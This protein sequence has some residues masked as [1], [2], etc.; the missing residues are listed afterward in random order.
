MKKLFC[1]LLIFSLVFTISACGKVDLPPLPEVT[2]K[3][4]AAAPASEPGQT[5]QAPEAASS[6]AGD[7]ETIPAAS[8]DTASLPTSRAS[9]RPSSDRKGRPRSYVSVKNQT[10]PATRARKA[11][12]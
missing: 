1:I 2:E 9:R 7:S 5:V 10:A 12:A 8:K 6:A 4:E 11:R 3:P